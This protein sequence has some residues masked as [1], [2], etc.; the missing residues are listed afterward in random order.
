M[1]SSE[2][3]G[4]SSLLGR[5]QTE[6]DLVPEPPSRLRQ[7]QGGIHGPTGE[8]PLSANIVQKWRVGADVERPKKRNWLISKGVPGTYP[9]GYRAP[10]LQFLQG[11]QPLHH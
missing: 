5:A 9:T 3:L 2:D 6:G 7:V 11:F 4:L 1:T 10:R 8:E